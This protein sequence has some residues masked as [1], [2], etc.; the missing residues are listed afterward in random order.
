MLVSWAVPQGP[1]G[2]SGN[3]SASDLT[4]DHPL[5]YASFDSVIPPGQYGACT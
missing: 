1:A 4:E 2:G 3:Q 5:E